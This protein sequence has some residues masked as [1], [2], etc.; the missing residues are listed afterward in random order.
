MSCSQLL[1]IGHHKNRYI[2]SLKKLQQYPTQK[3]ILIVGEDPKLA[4]EKY[5]YQVAQEIKND[6][7]RFWEVSIKKVNKTQVLLTIEQIFEIV[8]SEKKLGNQVLINTTGALR[9]LSIAGYIVACIT[10]AKIFSAVPNYDNNKELDEIDQ[11]IDIP[12]LPIELPTNEQQEILSAIGDSIESV[13]EII[14]NLANKKGT[15]DIVK[16]KLT[17]ERAR[18]SHHLKY[19]ESKGLLTR[20]KNGRKT[21]VMI[22]KTGKLL[23]KIGKIILIE[24]MKL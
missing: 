2:S 24:K 19:L 8:N 12:I 13:D 23:L 18:L 5:V 20:E 9:N 6:L 1:F 4:G 11:I 15:Q 10:G 21:R 17:N 7:E 14:Y 16:N 3:L 22:T